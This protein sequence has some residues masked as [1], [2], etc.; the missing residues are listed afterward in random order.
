MQGL[1][2]I[3]NIVSSLFHDLSN[4]SDGIVVLF[5]K[6]PKEEIANFANLI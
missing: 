3:G 2:D 1:Q 4:V 5:N 6:T